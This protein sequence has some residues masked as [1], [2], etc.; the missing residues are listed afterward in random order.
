MGRH[1]RQPTSNRRSA[2]AAPRIAPPPGPARSPATG[3]PGACLQRLQL[4]QAS[5]YWPAN[6]GGARP[7]A[8]GI[9]QRRLGPHRPVFAD[10]LG[11]VAGTLSTR[12]RSR[13][14]PKSPVV[15]RRAV[16]ALANLQA[17]VA[18]VVGRQPRASVA[19]GFQLD[20]AFARLADAGVGRGWV[21]Q[22]RHLRTF[23]APGSSAPRPQGFRI[24]H[25]LVVAGI[26][27]VADADGRPRPRCRRCNRSAAAAACPAGHQRQPRWHP[28]GIAAGLLRRHDRPERSQQ[29]RQAL[30]LRFFR[31]A[32]LYTGDVGNLVGQHAGHLVLAGASTSPAFIP[33]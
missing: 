3:C 15:R 19:T 17:R 7:I 31:T 14:K 33:T 18:A 22:A 1:P 25:R 24:R 21:W 8:L 4:G 29:D 26:G 9:V 10:G 12:R 6:P 30:A 16:G 13:A 20:S 23:V 2:S 28:A 27:E 5:R 11:R 32:Q